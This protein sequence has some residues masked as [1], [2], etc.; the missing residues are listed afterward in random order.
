MAAD[1][2]DGLLLRWPAA[3]ARRAGRSR[4]AGVAVALAGAGP[5][6]CGGCWAGMPVAAH[7]ASPAAASTADG[8]RK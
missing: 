7:A 5:V 3:H 6:A 8:A 2:T 4:R 1:R